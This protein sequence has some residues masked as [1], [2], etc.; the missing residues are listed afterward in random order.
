[1]LWNDFRRSSLLIIPIWGEADTLSCSMMSSSKGSFLKVLHEAGCEVRDRQS[2][3]G[4]SSLQEAQLWPPNCSSV[5]D[6]SGSSDPCWVLGASSRSGI[7]S[8]IRHNEGNN[9]ELKPPPFTRKRSNYLQRVHTHSI[10]GAARGF[11]ILSLLAPVYILLERT[12]WTWQRQAHRQKTTSF[13]FHVHA[14]LSPNM[15]S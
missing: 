1:M 12:R 5:S 2:A 14:V 11:I 6:Q 10:P 13:C 15:F 9:N 4:V 7:W 3:D 8:R